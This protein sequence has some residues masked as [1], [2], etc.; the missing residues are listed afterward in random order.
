VAG[1]TPAVN[2]HGIPVALV[3]GTVDGMA[4]PGGAV[5]TY[6]QIQDPPKALVGVIGANHYGECN[7]NNPPGALKETSTPTIDQQVAIETVARWSAMWLRAVV[8][9]DPKAKEYFFSCGDSSDPNVTVKSV[10]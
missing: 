1:S 6:N 5:Q 4:N 3:Q 2:N 8:L 10:H 7:Q 9:N